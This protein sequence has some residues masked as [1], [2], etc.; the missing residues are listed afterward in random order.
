MDVWYNGEKLVNLLEQHGF[1]KILTL[2]RKYYIK[3]DYSKVKIPFTPDDQELTGEG[4]SF[5][6]DELNRFMDN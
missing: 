5:L 6:L 2:I 1:G 4:E 3:Q